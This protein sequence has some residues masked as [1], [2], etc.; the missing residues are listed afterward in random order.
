MPTHLVLPY[1]IKRP[2]FIE[3]ADWIGA[4]GQDDLT[5]RL[6]YKDAQGVAAQTD[7]YTVNA[8]NA[9]LC[10]PAA[11]TVADLPED[12]FTA[13]IRMAGMISGTIP[14]SMEYDAAIKSDGAGNARNF[15][16]PIGDVKVTAI[17]AIDPLTLRFTFQKTSGGATRDIDMDVR[18]LASYAFAPSTQLLIVAGAIKKQYPTY[19]QDHANGKDLTQ[20]QMDTIAAYVLGLDPWI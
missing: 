1:P 12:I 14:G 2:G 11:K 18:D 3:A 6:E 20:T 8:V 13:H 7:L 16:M 9:T 4:P 5:L 15:Q 10:L 19:I 17:A